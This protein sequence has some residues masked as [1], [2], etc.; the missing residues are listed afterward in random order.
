MEFFELLVAIIALALFFFFVFFYM[1]CRVLCLMGGGDGS[2][3]C[4]ILSVHR[5]WGL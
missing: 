3:Q 5:F 4:Y 1:S 2:I